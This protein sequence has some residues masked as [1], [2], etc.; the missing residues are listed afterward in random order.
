[1]KKITKKLHPKVSV[2][3]PA[4]NEEKFIAN[5][6]YSIKNQNTSYKYDIYVIDNASIDKTARI[7]RNLGAKV[8]TE[9]VK[10]LSHARQEGLENIEADI[11]IYVDAD[12]L[13]PEHWIEKVISYLERNPDVVAVSSNYRY[14]DG[15]I[16]FKFLMSLEQLILSSVL[17]Y[18]LRMTN[19]P[20][21]LVGTAFAVRTSALHATGGFNHKF[22]FYGE[23]VALAFQLI[24]KGKVHF[25]KKLFIKTSARRFKRLG[26]IRINY[27][28]FVMSY[29]LASGKID[30]A[31]DFAKKQKL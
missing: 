1:M 3:I 28:Y 13:L 5:C 22:P 18:M 21:P 4:H 20:D 9:P 2:V 31:S 10:G 11:I 24:T 8:I 30:E 26:M 16:S 17:L 12:T 25:L 6:I 19:Q 14:Y 29:F 15:D 7:A 23:D 27:I